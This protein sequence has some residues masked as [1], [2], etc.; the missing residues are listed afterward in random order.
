MIGAKDNA[1]ATN[2]K[3]AHLASIMISGPILGLLDLILG[4]LLVLYLFIL[5]RP[6][7]GLC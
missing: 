3:K 1:E 7:V 2:V 5:P 4:V 6:R